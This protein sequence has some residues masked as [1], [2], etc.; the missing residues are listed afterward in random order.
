ILYGFA[1]FLGCFEEKASTRPSLGTTFTASLNDVVYASELSTPW[2]MPIPK[3]LPKLAL[4][5]LQ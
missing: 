4:V 1:D 3:C 2:L 5:F